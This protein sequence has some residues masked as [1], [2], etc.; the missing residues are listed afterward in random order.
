MK[1]TGRSDG[2]SGGGELA[3]RIGSVVSNVE[4]VAIDLPPPPR[5][6]F[7]SPGSPAFSRPALALR[8]SAA[9]A[10]PDRASVARARP[11]GLVRRRPP[12]R[13]RGGGPKGHYPVRA[14]SSTSGQVAAA[15]RRPIAK[16]GAAGQWPTPSPCGWARRRQPRA[17]TAQ[18]GRGQRRGPTLLRPQ[19]ARSKPRA[20]AEHQASGQPTREAFRSPHSVETNA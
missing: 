20:R 19:T 15:P 12:R 7:A 3:E 8:G 4:F 18:N 6:A 11:H 9:G 10:L 5:A 1:A 17:P 13:T 14:G 2:T 16:A